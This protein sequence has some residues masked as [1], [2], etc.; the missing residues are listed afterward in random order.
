MSNLVLN[1][2]S[3]NYNQQTFD[4][5]I[6]AVLRAT[7]GLKSYNNPAT[8][9]VQVVMGCTEEKLTKTFT[10]DPQLNYKNFGSLDTARGVLT[11]VFPKIV[12]GNEVT[13]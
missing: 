10:E 12:D 2:Q 13:I 4:F 11:M 1:T 6:R 9:Q 8:T 5:K 3:T 7:T